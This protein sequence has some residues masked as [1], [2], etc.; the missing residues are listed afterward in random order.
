MIDGEGRELDEEVL[1]PPHPD[2]QGQDP[3]TPVKGNDGSPAD[4]PASVAGEERSVEMKE[5][6]PKPASE[7]KDAT[8]ESAE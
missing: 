2:V 5:D 4:Q 3:E 8:G 7:A 6:E 1:A